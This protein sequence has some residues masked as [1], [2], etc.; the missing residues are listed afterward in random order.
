MTALT[1]KSLIVK[2]YLDKAGRDVEDATEAL[3]HVWTSDDHDSIARLTNATE[4]LVR[5]LASV[6]LAVERLAELVVEP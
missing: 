6:S 4:A 1:L 5:A 2:P 3:G